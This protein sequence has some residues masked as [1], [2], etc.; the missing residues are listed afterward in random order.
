MEYAHVTIDFVPQAHLRVGSVLVPV[1]FL[2]QTHEP[3]TFFSVERPQVDTLLIP[4]TWMEV[5]AGWF[6]HRR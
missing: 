3:P 2:N 6:E 4:T 5:G 1:G